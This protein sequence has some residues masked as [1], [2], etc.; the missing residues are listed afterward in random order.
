M[1]V[2]RRAG[3]VLLL[4]DPAW[5][6]DVTHC[7]TAA[8][9]RT[10]LLVGGEKYAERI[11]LLSLLQHMRQTHPGSPSSTMS[12]VRLLQDIRQVHPNRLLLGETYIILLVKVHT[13]PINVRRARVRR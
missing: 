12:T 7:T 11:G 6:L 13:A 4:D 2:P 3:S 5:S 8:E 1:S 10:K 9:K